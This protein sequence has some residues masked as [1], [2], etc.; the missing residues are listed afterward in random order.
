MH[1]E[2]IDGKRVHLVGGIVN[3]GGAGGGKADSMT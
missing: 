3:G 1:M 2:I